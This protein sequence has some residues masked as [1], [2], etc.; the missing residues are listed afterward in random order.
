M[1]GMFKW[2]ANAFGMGLAA[3]AVVIIVNGKAKRSA[4]ETGG[5]FRGLETLWK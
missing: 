2:N 4:Q 5:T 3:A 1:E